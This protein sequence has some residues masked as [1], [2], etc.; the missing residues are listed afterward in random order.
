LSDFNHIDILCH[1]I[2]QQWKGEKQS[3]NMKVKQ[4]KQKEQSKLKSK[5]HD[6]YMK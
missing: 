6:N 3:K 2:L 5:R 4:I 1:T